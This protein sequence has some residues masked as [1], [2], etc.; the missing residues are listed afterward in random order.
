MTATPSHPNFS[1]TRIVALLEGTSLLLLLFIAVPL[2]Y[3]ADIP[4]GVKL[5]GP[6]HGV[7]FLW[8]VALMLLHLLRRDLTI[9]QNILGIVASFMP[10]G[11]FIFKAKYLNKT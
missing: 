2:K 3:M 7:L 9:P 8:F 11:T 10:F 1:L 5:I 4:M 6:V